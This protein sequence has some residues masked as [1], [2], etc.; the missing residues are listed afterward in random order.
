MISPKIPRIVCVVTG[1]RAEYGSLYWLLKEIQDDSDL[2]LQI[3]VTGTHLSP[4]FRLTHQLIGND[5]FPI[6]AKVEMLLSSD[7]EVGITKSMGLGLIGYAD[8]LNELK[9]DLIVVLGDRFEMF[10]AVTARFIQ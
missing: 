5:V 1:S 9:P 7:S 4:K 6:S 3:I 8:A 10:S 2:E